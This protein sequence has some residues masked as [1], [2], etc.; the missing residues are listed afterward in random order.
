[1]LKDLTLPLWEY[2][3]FILASVKREFMIRYR[4]SVLGSLWS[5]LNPLAMI[6]V[7]TVIFSQIMQ[8]KLPGVEN[9]L[10][11]SI[12][13]CAGILTWGL[14]SEILSRSVNIFVENANMIKKLSFPKISLPAIVVLSSLTNF[15]IIF[16]IFVGFLLISGN[17]PAWPVL[18]LPFLL[19]LQVMFAASLGLILGLL[20]VFFRDVGQFVGIVLQF[21]FWFTPIVYPLSIVPETM[22]DWIQ[23]NPMTPLMTAYQGIFVLNQWPDWGSLLPLFIISLLT[24][25]AGLSLF[26]KLS[27]E[28]VDEL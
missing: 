7:Y 2:R 21:W 25:L 11:Y 20:N 24:A 9:G 10:A 18:A 1:M 6:L 28:M 13:L 23:F 15:G 4:S 8:A 22:Q 17:V 12:Y 14:H 27:P 3:G 26:R 16:G 19:V 5:F